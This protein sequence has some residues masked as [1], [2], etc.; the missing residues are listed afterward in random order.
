MTSIRPIH[1]IHRFHSSSTLYNIRYNS[2]FGPN[3]VPPI[4]E[5]LKPLIPF[6][7]KWSII[8]SLAVH[9]LQIRIRSKEEMARCD[10]QISVLKGLIDKIG[11]GLDLSDSGMRRELEM[12]GLRDRTILTK[13]EMSGLRESADVGWREALFGRRKRKDEVEEKR[14]IDEWVN[15]M[16]SPL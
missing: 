10:A 2:S 13:D 7:I 14:E 9:L 5:R 12:V 1:R 16:F 6:F 11:R 15:S 4:R 8:T 3:N